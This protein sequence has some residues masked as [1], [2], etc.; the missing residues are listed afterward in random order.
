MEKMVKELK[1]HGLFEN[2]RGQTAEKKYHRND[3]SLLINKR[4][5]KSKNFY[6]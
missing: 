5:S 3:R 4:Y 6:I 2:E 1:N